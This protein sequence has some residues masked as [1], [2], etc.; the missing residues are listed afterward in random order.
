MCQKHL[1]LVA[2]NYLE[3]CREK[4]NLGKWSN[5]LENSSSF[6]T[7]FPSFLLSFPFSLFPS[8]SP[9][10]RPHSHLL[11]QNNNHCHHKG[12]TETRLDVVP[13]DQLLLWVPSLFP[14]LLAGTAELQ[15]YCALER[16]L[17]FTPGVPWR[18]LNLY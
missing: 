17:S 9:H 6:Q 16:C 15:P 4:N 11:L 3:I 2:Q 1:S 13:G 7:L 18:R 8:L 5:V 14:F 10:R 12:S